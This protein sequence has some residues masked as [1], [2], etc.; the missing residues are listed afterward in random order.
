MWGKVLGGLFGMALAK[1]PGLLVGVAIGHWF[2]RSLRSSFEGAGGFAALK[3]ESA[4]PQGLFMYSTFAVMGHLAKADGQVTPAHIE[5]ASL[6]MQQLGLNS[7]QQVEAQHAFREG[8]SADFPLQT[9]L[10]QLKQAFRWRPDL[11]QMFLEIQIS[12]AYVDAK[13]S[14]TELQLLQQV[15][16]A[17][18]ISASKLQYLLGRY[19]AEARFANRSAQQEVK[20]STLDD[21]YQLLGVQSHCSESELKKAYKKQM[22]QHHPDKLMSQGLPKEMLELAKRKTQDVQAAYEVIRQSRGGR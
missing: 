7:A 4:D 19:E 10:G 18:S 5:K 21:A 12:I 20:A 11:L 1:W 14:Q 13:L 3:R 6:F 16:A 2:D 17:L 8:K 9:Q 15:A 22:A